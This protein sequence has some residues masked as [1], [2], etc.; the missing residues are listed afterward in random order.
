MTPWPKASFKIMTQRIEPFSLNL[1]QRNEHLFLSSDAKN[2]TILSRNMTQRIEPCVKKKENRTLEKGLI[3]F[4]LFLWTSSQCDSKSWS[5]FSRWREELNLSCFPIWLKELKYFL[6]FDSKNCFFYMTQRVELFLNLTW[7]FFI[8]YDSK[9]W[10]SFLNMTQRID[11]FFKKNMIQ[12]IEPLR[13]KAERI[14]FFLNMTQRICQTIECHLSIIFCVILCR[15]LGSRNDLSSVIVAE[16]AQWH[17][18]VFGVYNQCRSWIHVYL[19]D[20]RRSEA[21]RQNGRIGPSQWERLELRSTLP[22]LVPWRLLHVLLHQSLSR[23]LAYLNRTWL[24]SSSSCLPWW[25][26]VQHLPLSGKRR[27]VVGVRMALKLGGSWYDATS[28]RPRPE[29][30]VCCNRSWTQCPFLTTWLGLRKLW[31]SGS[32]RSLAGNLLRTTP[33]T[34]V[35]RLLSFSRWHRNRYDKTCISKATQSMEWLVLLS[36]MLSCLST[37]GRMHLSRWKLERDWWQEASQG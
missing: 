4:N 36:W 12:R 29:R 16:R 11:P 31:A 27:S 28:Q 18:R 20:L 13:K 25:Q 14:N 23:L 32:W 10:T 3:E 24:D 35:W 37:L 5:L 2:W 34:R 26:R 1:T 17:V 6:Q 7:N 9:N 8:E 22:S 30:W 15:R 21:Q 33:W 19:G